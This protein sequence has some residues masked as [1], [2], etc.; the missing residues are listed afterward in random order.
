MDEKNKNVDELLQL[1]GKGISEVRFNEMKADESDK[2][3]ITV[4]TEVKKRRLRVSS[5]A[6][7]CAVLLCLLIGATV[8]TTATSEAFRMKL[9]GFIFEEEADYTNIVSD[10]KERIMYPKYLPEGY[11]KMSEDNFGTAVVIN[12]QNKSEDDFITVSE[13]FGD[14]FEESIDNETTNRE[15]CLVGSYEAYFFDTKDNDDE[16]IYTLIWEENDIFIEIN[17][18]LGKDEMIKIGISLE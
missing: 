11:E 9:F 10:K 14:D 12:Y 17:S 13:E 18:T 3:D 15:R 7:V 4:I 6:K 2:K 8:I 16:S 1:L 5:A